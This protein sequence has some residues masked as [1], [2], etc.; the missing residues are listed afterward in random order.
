MKLFRSKK[1][2]CV[3]RNRFWGK[4][5]DGSDYATGMTVAEL[6]RQ[7]ELYS[8]TVEVCVAVCPKKYWNGGGYLG[9]LKAVERG[10]ETQVWLKAGVIDPSM[11]L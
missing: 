4:N 5:E 11:E 10:I 6:R 8:D 3:A 1:Q 2:Q 7:L 9:V